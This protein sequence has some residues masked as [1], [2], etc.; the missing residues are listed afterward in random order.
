MAAKY[1]NDFK[2]SPVSHLY[3]N[4]GPVIHSSQ[5]TEQVAALGEICRTLREAVRANELSAAQ[6]QELEPS[7]TAME[8]ASRGATDANAP[9]VRTAVHVAWD[10]AREVLAPVLTAATML[11]FGLTR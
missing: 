5:A 8:E 4:E 1:N 9:A 11:F 10:T 3:Q 7:L 2:H 6:I